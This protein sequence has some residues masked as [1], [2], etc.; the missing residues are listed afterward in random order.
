MAILCLLHA[1][2]TLSSLIE[3]PG[4]AI[5]LTPLLKALS[6]LSPNGKNASEPNA[7]SVLPSSHALFS[8]LVNTSGL[9]V[10]TLYHSPS[11]RRSSYS[12]PIYRSI[13]LSLSARPTLSLNGRLRTL[14]FWRRYQ[15]SAF[16]PASL[17]QWILDC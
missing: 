10:N 17:V 9:L 13:A 7:T 11:A 15:L 6:I 3:P 12:S 1:S 16:W 14:G 2:I 5:Y 4:C 8:S